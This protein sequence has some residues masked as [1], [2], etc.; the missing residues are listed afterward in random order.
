VYRTH[1]VIDGHA[2][3][4]LRIVDDGVDIGGGSPDVHLDLPRMAGS[5]L[6]AVFLAAWIDPALAGDG[7]WDRAASLLAAIRGVAEANPDRAGFAR[8]GD[9]VRRH[10]AEGRLALLAGIEN[11][12]AFEGRVENVTRARELGASYVTL[13]WM[14]SNELGDAGGGEEIHGGLS[15]FGREVVRA[16]E[17]DGILVDLAHA[18]PSTF[19]D[20]LDTASGPVVVSHAAT[21][22]RGAHPRNVSDDQ[23]RAVA[24]TGGLVGIAFM[25]AYLDPADPGSADV[26]TI[27]DHLDRVA[28]VAGTDHVALGSDFDGV[29]T[30]PR[31]IRGVED[32]PVLFAELT[33]RGWVGRDLGAL[34][35]GNWLRVL[36]R[37]GR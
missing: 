14:N 28:D 26:A 7:A 20:A 17:R 11:G 2:D 13:T 25:P 16:M 12:Q 35:G 30:L 22:A 23:I 1:L 34:L 24:D 32:L 4:P 27:A 36:D 8:T 19:F 10:V 3:T 15:P 9:D 37:T 21:E 5:G 33:R 29:P 6:D 31:G 18:A